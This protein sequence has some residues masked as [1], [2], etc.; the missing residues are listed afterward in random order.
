MERTIIKQL[1]NNVRISPTKTNTMI[2]TNCNK[3][4]VAGSYPK[5]LCLQAECSEYLALKTIRELL[6][7]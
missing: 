2:C 3:N 1:L 4:L 5:W 6:I 7:N